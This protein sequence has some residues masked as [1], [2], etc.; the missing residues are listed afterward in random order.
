MIDVHMICLLRN[1][2]QFGPV[3][4]YDKQVIEDNPDI[5][6]PVEKKPEKYPAQKIQRQYIL[7]LAIETLEIRMQYN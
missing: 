4:L 1:S 6:R 3:Y 7:K 2:V 5:E